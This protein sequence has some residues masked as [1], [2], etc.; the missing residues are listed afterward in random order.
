VEDLQVVTQQAVKSRRYLTDPNLWRIIGDRLVGKG[1]P[2]ITVVEG[3]KRLLRVLCGQDPCHPAWSIV[4]RA[5][6]VSGRIGIAQPGLSSSQ[7]RTELGTT[8]PSIA[9]S[10]IREFLTVLHDATADLGELTL[11]VS[12]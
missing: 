8:R 2:A 7:L 10:Q 4:R 3:N 12:D 11:L 9:A 6:V 1:S 5:P